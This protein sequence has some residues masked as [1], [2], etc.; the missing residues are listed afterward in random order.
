MAT[1]RDDS[2]P[3]ELAPWLHRLDELVRELEQY[4][5]PEVG[6][7]VIEL[8]QCVDIVHRSGLRRVAE[9]LR[10][11]G[12]LEQALEQPEVRLLFALYDLDRAGERVRAEAVLES[13]R[14]Y[15]A[16][17]GI[18]VEL[19]GSAMGLL[20][21]RLTTAQPDPSGGE[22][23][24]WIE[25]ALRDAMPDVR[26]IDVQERVLPAGF[27]PLASLAGGGGGKPAAT[28][29]PNGGVNAQETAGER[30]PI[31]EK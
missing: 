27:V 5:E 2:P 30:P 1:P 15:L 8:L 31:P 24:A 11:A 22:I 19:L 23:R 18:E 17:H 20:E 3:T 25:R 29:G 12:L 28:T 9:M 4:P 26:G 16:P 13:M 6:E 7:R 10:P 21:L 14:P